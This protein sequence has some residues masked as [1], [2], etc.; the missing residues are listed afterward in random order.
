MMQCINPVVRRFV[1]GAAFAAA[2]GTWLAVPPPDLRAMPRDAPVRIAQAAP[3]A[4]EAPPPAAAEQAPGAATKP[5]A[6]ITI[7]SH[8]ITID[9]GS[10]R[11]RVGG[12]GEDREYESFEEFVHEAPW[13][14]TLVF[15]VVL[16][17]FLVPLAVI[18]LLVWYKV[19]KN[20]MFNE[21]MIRLA[22]KG[23]SPVEAME[24]LAADKPPPIPP[25]PKL[26]PHEQAIVLRLRAAW[27]DLRK[28]VIMAAVGAALCAYSLLDHGGANGVGLVLLFVGLGYC[29]LWYFEQREPAS[30]ARATPPPDGA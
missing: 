2:L 23:V 22:E 9:K 13:L 27:S 3:K 8:G 6:E 29:A 16:L 20:R 24:A 11:V 5:A 17:V 25:L 7:D 28:G 19:R 4:A 30:R 12:P 15:L 21:T 1:L 18:V 26:P 10:K 14:A